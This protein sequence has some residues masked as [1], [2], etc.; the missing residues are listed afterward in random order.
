MRLYF[1]QAAHRPNNICFLLESSNNRPRYLVEKA[2]VLERFRKHEE[3]VDLSEDRDREDKY[4]HAV[5]LSEERK[6]KKRL[7]N[8]PNGLRQAQWQG[9]EKNY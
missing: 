7:A 1:Q 3:A 4:E 8:T 5:D 2:I 9:P 6:K